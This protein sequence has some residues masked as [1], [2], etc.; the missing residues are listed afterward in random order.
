[1][2]T[3]KAKHHILFPVETI[4]RELDFRLFLAAMFVRPGRRVYVGNMHRINRMIDG[5]RGGLYVGKHIFYKESNRLKFYDALKRNNFRLVYLQEEGGVFPGGVNEWKQ[6]LDR[7][8][9]VDLKW[10]NADDWLCNWGELQTQ[11]YAAK[12]SQKVPNIA[13]TGHPRFDLYKPR[14]R[15]YFEDDI[16]A[17]QAQYGAYLL[18][19]T[20]Q[21]WANNSRGLK[22]T[23]RSDFGY[24]T[25][26]PVAHMN[27]VR[28]W[29]HGMQILAGM[30]CLV[31]RL[32]QQYP[33]LKIIVRPHPSE[34]QGFYREA[35]HGVRNVHVIHSG[36]VT[37]WIM[38][39]KLLIHD[40]CTTAVEAA[41]AG[42]P[43]INYKT[44]ENAVFDLQLP[45]Q[46][47]VQ[48]RTE[49][50]VMAAVDQ[51]LAGDTSGQVTQAGSLAVSM[52]YNLRNDAFDALLR[53][54]ENALAAAGPP[55][56]ALPMY[57]IAARETWS[58]LRGW[59]KRVAGPLS[60]RYSLHSASRQKFY[61]F[62]WDMVN[63][64]CALIQQLLDKAIHVRM[65]SEELLTIETDK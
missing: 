29:A 54:M 5:L 40:G 8:F 7:Q 9:D 43:I 30:V 49:D 41:F 4:N 14:F 16:R 61:G 33:H 10:L 46:F 52:L 59:P 44:V 65:Y 58:R 17:L 42:T 45:N 34:N 6:E 38:A 31:H 62:Q 35:L 20:N 48:C 28:M 64:R 63:R 2:S 13:T 22:D 12:L 57:N 26:N 47:G 25:A 37:P 51:V 55:E 53:V 11:H 3:T 19:N 32:A 50:E 23:F 56:Q 24:G 27:H 39:S 15:R 36:P 18:V 21:S 60:R 1:M